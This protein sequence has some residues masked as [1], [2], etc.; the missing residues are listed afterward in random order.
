[1]NDYRT[2]PAGADQ[3]ATATAPGRAVN[4]EELRGFARRL[5]EYGLLNRAAAER[6][7]REASEAEV[8][9]LQHVIDSGLATARQATL[10]AAWEYGLPLVDLDALRLASLPPAKEYPEKLL[11]KLCVVPLVRRSH[12]LTV[13]VPYPP[14]WRCSTSCS[15]PPG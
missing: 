1:M 8:S 2:L 13:A 7:E 12:R 11:R 15:S 6:A 9:L 10:C 3:D 5:V 14:P 4:I